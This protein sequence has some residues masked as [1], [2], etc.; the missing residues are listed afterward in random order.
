ME[1]FPIDL[2]IRYG[3]RYLQYTESEIRVFPID[4]NRIMGVGWMSEVARVK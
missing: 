2:G 1:V 3:V 4:G